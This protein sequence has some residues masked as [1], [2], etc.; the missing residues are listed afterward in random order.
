MRITR[1]SFA[2]D[3]TVP[4]V[5]DNGAA[6]W[7]GR[8]GSD[9]TVVDVDGRLSLFVPS[10]DQ[11]VLL[12]ESASAVWGLCDG[13]HTEDAIVSTLAQRF[14]KAAD[15]IRDEVRPALARLTDVGALVPTADR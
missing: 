7:P 8:Q 15:E 2:R 1:D 10:S 5:T 6:T 3:A 11:I 14:G 9:V 12:N 4:T 13:R